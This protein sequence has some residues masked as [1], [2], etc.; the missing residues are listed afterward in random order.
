MVLMHILMLLVAI[1]ELICSY[2]V[3]V[4]LARGLI[5]NDSAIIGIKF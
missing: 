1:S 5:H 2:D 3:D 4:D